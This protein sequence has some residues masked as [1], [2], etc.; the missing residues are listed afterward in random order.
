MVN[1]IGR[2]PDPAAI[3]AIPGARLHL[4][5]KAPK[6]GRKVG[7][8]TVIGRSHDAIADAVAAVRSLADR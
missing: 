2:V 8:V 3:L 6:A 7:H 1:L 4:Y 5:G